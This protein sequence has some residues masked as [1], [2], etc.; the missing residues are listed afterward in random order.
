M[1]SHLSTQTPHDAKAFV[2]GITQR[3]VLMFLENVRDF[4]APLWRITVRKNKTKAQE[5]TRV[6]VGSLSTRK[7]TRNDKR[8]DVAA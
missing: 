4:T 1:Q 6:C 7:H 8:I 3:E 5:R 2:E